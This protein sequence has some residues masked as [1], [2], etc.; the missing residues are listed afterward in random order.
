MLNDQKLGNNLEVSTIPNPS[1]ERTERPVVK[2]D[3]RTVQD[4]RKTSRSQ[5]VDVNSFHGEIV[6]SERT[7]RPVVETSVTQT[8]SSEDSD[9]PNVETA[10]ERTRRLVK[11]TQKMCQ[12]VA[13][14]VLVM[15]AKDSTLET[16]HFVKDRGDPLLTM[17]I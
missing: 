1:R 13:K 6:S 3:T 9:G 12:M 2:D 16:K 10:H 17:T 7:G 11:Q 5:E 8:R 15:K 4:G 14:H